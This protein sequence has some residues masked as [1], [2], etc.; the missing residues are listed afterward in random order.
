MNFCLGFI[1]FITK[2]I[3]K[4]KTWILLIQ[5]KKKE[6]EMKSFNIQSL[7]FNIIPSIFSLSW[8]GYGMELRHLFSR[9]FLLIFLLFI[10]LSFVLGYN[11]LAFVLLRTIWNVFK[12]GWGYFVKAKSS[13]SWR[14]WIFVEKKPSQPLWVA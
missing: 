6:Y 3:K 12:D 10:F 14:G 2:W 11:F 9:S 13:S 5:Y 8:R 1:T 7:I 4:I